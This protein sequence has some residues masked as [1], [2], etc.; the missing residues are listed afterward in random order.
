MNYIIRSLGIAFLASLFIYLSY[1]D[2]VIPLINTILGLLALYFLLQE[3]KRVWFFVG[4]FIGVLWFWWIAV[5]FKHYDMIWAIP[6]AIAI[7]SI[8]YA[9]IFWT[10]AY[11]AQRVTPKYPIIIKALGLLVISYI[12]PFAFDWFK[13]E[14][15]FVDSYIGIYKWQFAIVLFAISLSIYKRNLL[16][17]F[18]T[19]LA[20]QPITHNSR[21]LANIA[22][23]TTHTTVEDKWNENLH[24]KQFE[25]LF[26][27]I[28]KAIK[29]QKKI[30]V[31]PESVFP[32]FLNRSPKIIEELQKRAKDITIVTGGLYWDGKTPRNSTYIFNKD[33]MSI[34][35]KVVLVP[36]GESNPLP[37]FLSDWINEVFY[38]GA[39]DYEASKEVIDYK[40]DNEIY[41]NAICFE[42]TSETLYEKNPKNMIVISNNGWFNP[43]T[44]PILQKLLL[45][46]YNKKYGTRIYHAINMSDSYVIE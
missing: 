29:E 42:A 11:I 32:I 28:D 21:P 2:I 31:L 23:I 34:A 37:D 3:D 16:Y 14:L 40:I 33:K 5:S 38:D 45:K 6:I 4:A 15:I 1:F 27:S 7:I 19:I 44:E 41:R 26:G 24:S 17:L 46:Y 39:V 9:L 13:I 25:A 12:H 8:S 20:Y 30:V 43:S 22:L 18:I 36:F 35:N 10:I